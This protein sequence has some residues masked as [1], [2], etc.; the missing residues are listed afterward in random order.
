MIRLLLVIPFLA[1][2]I[3]CASAKQEIGERAQRVVG[4]ARVVQADVETVSDSLGRV[5]A[6]I[7]SAQVSLETAAE[8]TT[9]SL[10]AEAVAAAQDQLRQAERE[11]EAVEPVLGGIATNA[12]QIEQAAAPIVETLLDK[13]ED[14]PSFWDSVRKAFRWVAVLAVLAIVAGVLVLGRMY[15]FDKIFQ[16]VI[17]ILSLPFRW[18]AAKFEAKW[19]GP[20]K[21]AKEVASGKTPPK[22]LI[23]ALRGAFPALDK[24]MLKSP[25]PGP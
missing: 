15:G 20:A 9:E 4:L 1:A 19:A 14:K 8:L 12:S 24:A 18:I 22:E 3:G 23:A 5:E 25:K 11:V 7:S 6:G 10:V 2:L 16:P 17:T 21:L 13:V